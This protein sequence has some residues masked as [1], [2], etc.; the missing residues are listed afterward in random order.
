MLSDSEDTLRNLSYVMS[1]DDLKV[2]KGLENEFW[3]DATNTRGMLRKQTKTFER[4]DGMISLE[5]KARGAGQS[6]G[7]LRR[8][9]L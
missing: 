1:A 9:L 8:S 3:L 5:H 4:N 7:R 2:S 6:P